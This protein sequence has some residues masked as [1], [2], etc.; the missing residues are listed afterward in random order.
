M[1]TNPDF[2]FRTNISMDWYTSKAEATACLTKGGASAVN[3]QKMAFKEHSVTVTEFL[4]AA[5]GG[6]TFCNLF[7]L[8][9]NQKYRT[10]YKD[11][12]WGK[13]FPVYKRGKNEGGMK[14]AFKSDEFFKGAQTVFVDIDK[15]RFS[16]VGDYIACLTYKPT[17]VYMSYSDGLEKKGVVS[18]RF[19][20]VYVFDKVLDDDEFKHVSYAINDRIVIDTAEPMDDDC[21]TRKSQYMNG[22]Y[23]NPET[24]RSDI[25]YSVSDFPQ[26]EKAPD[27]EP[28]V[29]EKQEGAVIQFNQNLVWDMEHLDFG[30]FQY[31]HYSQY[32][33]R[34]RTEGKEWVNSTYQLTTDDYLQL[35]FYPQKQLDGQL[36]RR[37][38]GKMA[39]LRHL[40][41]PDMDPD[42]L[43]YNLYIDRERFFDNSDGVITIDTLI[44]K[45]KFAFSMSYEQLR[46]YCNFEIEYWHQNRPKFILH[47]DAPHTIGLVNQV[48]KEI[49]QQTFWQNYDTT[50]S[51][52]DNLV[53]I[54]VSK[55]TAYRY[56]QEKGINTNPQKGMTKKEKRA[57]K[58]TE[59][60]DKIETFV[61]YYDPSKKLAENQEVLM[62]HGLSLTISTISRWQMKYYTTTTSAPV[63]SEPV[64]ISYTVSDFDLQYLI[65]SA[66]PNTKDDKVWNDI[67]RSNWNFMECVA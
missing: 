66:M 44:R 63:Y 45:V 41:F 49:R 48:R 3:K 2:Q 16:N 53:N 23:G 39:C 64:N 42:T 15:T 21:G 43:L 52:I 60:N 59:R 10:E 17:C 28:V 55:S 18:R 9:P 61:T 46:A 24:Y 14:L 20:L 51:L 22:C 11:G 37:K 47:P 33:Y 31:F 8:D 67:V 36:R 32:E 38:L 62:Q 6:H 35:W 58:R 30:K 56:C 12:K 4:A 54:G 34:Y 50:K 13:V 25:I 1:M 40:M 5:T 7:E 27:L 65:D 19:R 26:E 29:E 57:A